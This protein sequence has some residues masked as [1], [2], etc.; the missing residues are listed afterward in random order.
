MNEADMVTTLIDAA[1]GGEWNLV[2]ASTLTMLVWAARRWLPQAKRIPRSYVPW[3]SVGLGVAG[4]VAASLSGTFNTH[5]WHAWA[6]AIKAG[7]VQGAA[8]SG[9]WSMIGKAV[10]A[11]LPPPKNSAAPADAPPA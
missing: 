6:G 8:A 1:K 4:S 5:D 2:A 3:I 11:K 7:V 10:D 9:V